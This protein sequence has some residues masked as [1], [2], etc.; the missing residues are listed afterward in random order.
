MMRE[1]TALKEWTLE[2]DFDGVTMRAVLL[3]GSP[4]CPAER[5]VFSLTRN[6]S[7]FHPYVPTREDL[8]AQA[9][10]F[11]GVQGIGGWVRVDWQFSNGC[12]RET[13]K[14][15]L[16]DATRFTTVHEKWE[17]LV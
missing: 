17:V 1:I 2:Y 11:V 5:H 3:A 12:H 14:F 15:V 7:F 6:F 13:W 8:F 9:N 16:D 10:A 4:D